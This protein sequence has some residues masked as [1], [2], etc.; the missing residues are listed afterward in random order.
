MT[1]VFLFLTHFTLTDSRSIHIS[2]NDPILFLFMAEKYSIVSYICNTSL[3]IH[4]LMDIYVV[5]IS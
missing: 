1:F 4:L 3:S 2:S 5:S